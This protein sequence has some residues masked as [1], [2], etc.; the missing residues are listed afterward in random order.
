[1]EPDA[2]ASVQAGVRDAVFG[3]VRV[4]VLRG[5]ETRGDQGRGVDVYYLP[6]ED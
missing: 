3:F 1:M 4:A 5:G 6:K 2:P